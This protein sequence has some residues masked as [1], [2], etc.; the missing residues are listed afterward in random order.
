MDKTTKVIISLVGGLAFFVITKEL[1]ISLIICLWLFFAL[2]SLPHQIFLFFS[3]FLLVYYLV[4]KNISFIYPALMVILGLLLAIFPKPVVK[5]RQV[6]LHFW[7]NTKTVNLM[8]LAAFFVFA[9][10]F[11]YQTFQKQKQVRPEMQNEKP[12]EKVIINLK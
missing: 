8:I 5:E 11:S 3:I 6:P 7:R 1:I 2:F 10:F 9:L 4:F 12:V